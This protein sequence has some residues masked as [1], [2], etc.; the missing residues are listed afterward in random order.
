MC[1]GFWD[2]NA[3]KLGCDDGHKTINIM[4][5]I[6]FKKKKKSSLKQSNQRKHYSWELCSRKAGF[7]PF[8]LPAACPLGHSPKPQSLSSV[9]AN[10]HA[11]SPR[12]PLSLHVCPWRG[13]ILKSPK[14]PRAR[15][16]TVMSTG[17]ARR[18]RL[19]G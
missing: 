3:I 13:A 14:P 10:P 5:F 9:G 8:T 15:V 2:G 6:E 17:H 12:P 7:V 1:W 19:R 11:L 16:A 18:L 4:K